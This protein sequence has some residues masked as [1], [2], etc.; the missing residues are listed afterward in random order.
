VLK[1]L[2]TLVPTMGADTTAAL[3]QIVNAPAGNAFDTGYITAEYE[4]HAFLRDLAAAY[5][6]NS[7]ANTSDISEKHGRQLAKVAFF[8]FTEHTGITHRILQELAV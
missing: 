1:E 7:D 4:N 3:D 6:K 8:A 5:L 2:G